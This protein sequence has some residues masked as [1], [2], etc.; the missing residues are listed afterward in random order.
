MPFLPAGLMHCRLQ[1]ALTVAEAQPQPYKILKW[2][3]F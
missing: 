1:K 2:K 3:R